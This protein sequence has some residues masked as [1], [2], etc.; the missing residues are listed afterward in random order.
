MANPSPLYGAF[1]TLEYLRPLCNTLEFHVMLQT[2][3]F[4]VL[5]FLA[6]SRSQQVQVAGS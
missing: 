2:R 6:A 4:A 5:R 3:R 1:Y